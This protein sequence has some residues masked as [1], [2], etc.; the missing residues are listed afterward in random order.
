[1]PANQ[2]E[3]SYLSLHALHFLGY[4]TGLIFAVLPTVHL[5]LLVFLSNASPPAVRLVNAEKQVILIT[6]SLNKLVTVDN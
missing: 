4:L 3:K 6:I 5:L 2:A 1:M